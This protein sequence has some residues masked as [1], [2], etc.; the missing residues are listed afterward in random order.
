MTYDKTTVWLHAGLAF[1]VSTQL[2]FGLVMD[3]PRP[4]VPTGGAGDLFFQAHR[5]IGLAVLALL[6]AHWLWQLSGRAS[7]GLKSLYPWLIKRPP[8]S[9]KPSRL[10][11]LAG[12]MQGLGLLLASVMA[13]TGVTLFFGL[14]TDGGA[15]ASISLIRDLHGNMAI[16]LWIYLGLHLA[17]SLFRFL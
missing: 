16:P 1:G 7:N 12:T 15:S 9:P 4:G 8:S 14:A 17:I 11:V 6:S 13:L 10:F 5:I 3:A 2:I